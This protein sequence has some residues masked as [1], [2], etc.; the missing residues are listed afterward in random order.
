M[1]VAYRRRG[2]TGAFSRS[3]LLLLLLLLL[4]L[5]CQLVGSLHVFLCC[6]STGELCGS[7]V[8]EYQGQ[9]FAEV[10]KFDDSVE[11]RPISCAYRSV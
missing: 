5:S 9:S 10:L 6:C 11:P 3:T 4:L 8:M 1:V 7:Y 2:L